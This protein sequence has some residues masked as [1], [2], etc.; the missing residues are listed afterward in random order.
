MILCRKVL[1]KEQCGTVCR[2][3]DTAEIDH[4]MESVIEISEPLTLAR[5]LE[6]GCVS[7]DEGDTFSHWFFSIRKILLLI[8]QRTILI[9]G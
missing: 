1:L 7:K 9:P 6:A 8:F 2:R 3:C 4:K 5:G